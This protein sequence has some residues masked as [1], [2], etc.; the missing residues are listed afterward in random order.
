MKMYFNYWVKFMKKLKEDVVANNVGTGNIAG[1][2][3]G[4]NGEPGVDKK[5]KIKPF[6]TFIKRKM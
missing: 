4:Q 1:T 6:L 3:I 5:R 2:G